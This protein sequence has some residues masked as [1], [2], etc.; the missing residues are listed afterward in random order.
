MELISALRLEQAHLPDQRM[1]K[2]PYEIILVFGRVGNESIPLRGRRRCRHGLSMVPPWS[3]RSRGACVTV[4]CIQ[5]TLIYR[6]DRLGHRAG[7]SRQAS[8]GSGRP[9]RLLLAGTGFREPVDHRPQNHRNQ[10]ERAPLLRIARRRVGA[11]CS[12]GSSRA[13]GG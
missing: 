7:I 4:K 13:G 9:G 6:D 10:L 11:D 2:R 8:R 12:R 1:S 3:L 5:E